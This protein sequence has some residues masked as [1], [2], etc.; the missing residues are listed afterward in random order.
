MDNPALY[1]A[2]AAF[3]IG[4]CLF[5]LA[6]GYAAGVLTTLHRSDRPNKLPLRIQ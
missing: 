3:T 4:A 6:L 5:C 2:A 1:P